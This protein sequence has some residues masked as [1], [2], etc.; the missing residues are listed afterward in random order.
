MVLG[1][2]GRLWRL[3]AAMGALDSGHATLVGISA[4][5]GAEQCPGFNHPCQELPRR[6]TI[7]VLRCHPVS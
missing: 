6:T 1:Q 5:Q 3:R 2:G 4:S 7:A